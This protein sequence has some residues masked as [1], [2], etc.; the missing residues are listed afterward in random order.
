MSKNG[1]NLCLSC[2]HLHICVLTKLK[3]KVWS[4]SEYDE[5]SAEELIKKTEITKHKLVLA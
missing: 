4:C 1:F 2:M 5:H 3:E